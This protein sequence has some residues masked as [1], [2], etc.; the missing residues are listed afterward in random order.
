MRHRSRRRTLLCK[1]VIAGLWLLALGFAFLNRT[2]EL[3]LVGPYAGELLGAIVVGM[4]IWIPY[5]LGPQTIRE[6]H[7]Y[8]RLKRWREDAA[9]REEQRRHER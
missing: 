9:W 4:V 7:A 2:R 5:N 3:D 6:M 1:R 8:R